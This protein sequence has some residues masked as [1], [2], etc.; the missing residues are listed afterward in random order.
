MKRIAKILEFSRDR[1]ATPQIAAAFSLM[2]AHEDGV[3]AALFLSVPG[4]QA[5]LDVLLD[6]LDGF[7]GDPAPVLIELMLDEVYNHPPTTAAMLCGYMYAQMTADGVGAAEAFKTAVC[8]NV[9]PECG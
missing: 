9:A 2:M 3:P 8:E 6:K 5:A 1:R 7:E 4:T